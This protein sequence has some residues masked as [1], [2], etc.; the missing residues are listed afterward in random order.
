MVAVLGDVGTFVFA[1]PNENEEEISAERARVYLLLCAALYGTNYVFTKHLQE[2]IPPSALTLVRFACATLFFVPTLLGAEHA[3]AHTSILL[4]SIHIGL[5]SATGFITQSVAL[6]YASASKVAFFTCLAVVIVP[7][8]DTIYVSPV[9]Q[10]VVSDLE[11]RPCSPASLV[12]PLVAL[13]GVGLLE[14][15]GMEPASSSDLLLLSTPISFAVC[16]HKAETLCKAH[17]AHTSYITGVNLATVSVVA[18]LWTLAMNQLPLSLATLK[19]VLHSLS[20]AHVLLALVH[21]S[22]VSTAWTSFVEQKCKPHPLRVLTH[23]PHATNP[24]VYVC[25]YQGP[26]C[27]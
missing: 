20:V 11:R 25:S 7:L 23:L 19:V 13:L 27:R 3:E 12:P 2:S 26:L 8:L 17:P 4:E 22:V 14:F 9:A 16:L 5:W 18:L 6:E 1:L 24:T 10:S 15:G 21:T